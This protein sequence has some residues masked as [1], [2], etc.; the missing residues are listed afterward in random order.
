MR[1]RDRCDCRK[2]EQTV[3]TSSAM[4]SYVWRRTCALD[5]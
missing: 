5:R 2:L 3:R 1:Q 4:R